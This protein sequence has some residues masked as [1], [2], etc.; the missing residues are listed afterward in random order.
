MISISE[1]SVKN[2]DIDNFFKKL[3]KL[4]KHYD[5]TKGIYSGEPN[6]SQLFIY[7]IEKDFNSIFGNSNPSNM[8]ETSNRLV[9][10]DEVRD[11]FKHIQKNIK[12]YSREQIFR[13]MRNTCLDVIKTIE[14]EFRRRINDTSD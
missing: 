3:Y 13:D 11:V 6:V 14:M 5:F 1:R 4:T 7:L 10:L 8:S 9:N 2:K 12:R